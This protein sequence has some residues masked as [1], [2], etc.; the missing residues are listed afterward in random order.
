M[1]MP[2]C[3]HCG[4]PLALG[5]AEDD[6][7]RVWCCLLC[8]RATPTATARAQAAAADPWTAIRALR[9]QRQPRGRPPGSRTGARVPRPKLP[10]W[11]LRDGEYVRDE[12][13]S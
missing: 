5:Q 13:A 4:S 3:G 2:A 6:Q 10:I 7:S 8:A 1:P 9:A 11:R 12:E